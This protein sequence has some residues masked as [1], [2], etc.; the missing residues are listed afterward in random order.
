[1]T[2]DELVYTWHDMWCE[3][4][5]LRSLGVDV[6]LNEREGLMTAT[7]GRRSL[8][9][10][11]DGAYGW[12][13]ATRVACEPWSARAPLTSISRMHGLFDWLRGDA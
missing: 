10:W 5:D 9:L 6:R 4:V 2:D 7:R 13:C 1:M 8:I 11:H 12:E 3:V